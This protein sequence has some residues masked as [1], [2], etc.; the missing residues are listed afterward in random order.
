MTK[1]EINLPNMTEQ[2]LVEDIFNFNPKRKKIDYNIDS[3]K[4]SDMIEDDPKFRNN[5]HIKYVDKEELPQNLKRKP[6]DEYDLGKIVESNIIIDKNETIRL[7]LRHPVNGE[8]KRTI[9]D[10]GRLEDSNDYAMKNG[11]E[12]DGKEI[13]NDTE[14]IDGT[15]NHQNQVSIFPHARFLFTLLKY[16]LK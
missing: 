6:E 11:I 1:N 12:S 4:K 5:N 15:E 7:E 10:E 13:S 14:Y 3:T 8:Y 9:N 16:Q 2:N